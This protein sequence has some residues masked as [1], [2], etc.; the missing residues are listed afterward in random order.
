MSAAKDLMLQIV[1]LCNARTRSEKVQQWAKIKAHSV[2]KEDRIDY[3]EEQETFARILR[4]AP[5]ASLK[6]KDRVSLVL[7]D[8]TCP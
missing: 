8:S 3:K 6:I 7:N 1:K 5:S 4:K 2:L